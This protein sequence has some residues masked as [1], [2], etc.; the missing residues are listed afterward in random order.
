VVSWLARDP[1]TSIMCL[2]QRGDKADP[3]IAADK[4]GRVLRSSGKGLYKLPHA[5]R[6]DPEGNVWTVD[7]ESSTVV[8][9][10]PKGKKEGQSVASVCA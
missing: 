8:E 4:E 6:P 5:I 2:I 10:S 1:K 3:V 9:F 7:A